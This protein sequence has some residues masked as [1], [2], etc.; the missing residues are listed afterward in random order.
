MTKYKTLTTLLIT[1]N[2]F[3]IRPFLTHDIKQSL[4]KTQAC[5]SD[6]IST[7]ILKQCKNELAPVLTD[8]VNLSF[9][10]GTFTDL[11]KLS[12]VKSVYKKGDKSDLRK[13]QPI[14]LIPMLAKI[15]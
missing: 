13:Y 1:I 8:L 6:E 15:F 11:I 12:I 9:E 10:C 4:S 5:G 14:T 3:Y 2:S 7:K